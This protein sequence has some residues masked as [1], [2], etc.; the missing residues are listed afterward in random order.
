MKAH[1]PAPGRRWAAPGGQTGTVAASTWDPGAQ[2]LRVQEA[3]AAPGRGDRDQ[4]VLQPAGEPA[5]PRGQRL[6]QSRAMSQGASQTCQSPGSCAGEASTH[7]G[8]RG[9]TPST[10]GA[11]EQGGKGRLRKAPPSISVLGRPAFPCSFTY[12]PN[13]S[14]SAG[15]PGPTAA[16]LTDGGNSLLTAPGLDVGSW[17]Q[18]IQW[19]VGTRLPVTDGRPVP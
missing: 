12:S 11:Q 3:S 2:Q 17:C 5:Y 13:T 8:D 10:A 9:L 6:S 18:Q 19:P 16:S 1:H 7:P 15:E 4:W 14:R